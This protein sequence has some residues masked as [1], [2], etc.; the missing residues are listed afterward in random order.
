[1]SPAHDRS[2]ESPL[3]HCQY[4]YPNGG[5]MTSETQRKRSRQLHFLPALLRLRFN[6]I[7]GIKKLHW[8]EGKSGHGYGHFRSAVDLNTYATRSRPFTFLMTMLNVR[9][10]YWIRNPRNTAFGSRKWRNPSWYRI[11]SEMLGRGL[12]EKN[13]GIHLSDQGHFENRGLYEL[14]RRECRIII[15]C[16]AGKDTYYVFDDLAKAVERVRVDFEAEITLDTRPMRPPD[17]TTRISKEACFCGVIRYRSGLKCVIV[18][19][20]TTLVGGADR[21]YL[22][23]STQESGFPGSRNRRSVL[24]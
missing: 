4:Y 17:M 6:I 1:M 13:S 5:I 2:D 18:Y 9:L 19:I 3:S 16:D 21:G 8:G 24:R 20:N 15:V 10:G 12:S 23:L 7:R 22:F 14:I 11:F